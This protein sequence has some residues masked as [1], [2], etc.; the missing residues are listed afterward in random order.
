VYFAMFGT[1]FLM[2]QYLQAVHGYSAFEAGL[3]QVPFAITIILV[4]PRTPKLIARLGANRVVA[5]GLVAVAIAQF[6]MSRIEVSTPYL[7][8][9][10]IMLLMSAGMANIVAP[11]TTSI[12]AAVPLRKAGVGSAMNDTTRELG[13]ALGVAVL[14]SV[15]ASRF[16]S[17]LD[18]NLVALP[19]AVRR[20]AARS[21]AAAV[22]TGSAVGG[23]TGDAFATAARHAFMS[24]YH[25]ATIVAS[26][27]ALIASILV[28]RLLPGRPPI[29]HARSD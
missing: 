29:E 4:A 26:V 6:L 5:G 24:G 9:L 14:G 8:F 13:G 1:F 10:P 22:R 23:E 15:A 16:S 27:V 25:A 19:E 18:P 12:M 2:A 3:M 11:M 17:R 7:G 20:E 28:F 21:V